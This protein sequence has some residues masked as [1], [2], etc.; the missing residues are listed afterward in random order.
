MNRL[1]AYL[2]WFADNPIKF[3]VIAILFC[4]VFIRA[5][6]MAWNHG[7]VD[8]GTYKTAFYAI[9][10]NGHV[11]YTKYMDG[12]QDI[13][14]YPGLGFNFFDSELYQDL[15]GDGRIDRIRQNAAEWKMNTLN[16]ILIRKQDYERHKKRFD[17]ADVLL[18]KIIK[19]Y[20]AD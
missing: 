9:G 18:R 19:R 4:L 14:L 6:D 5:C 17:E 10:L 11:E 7:T 8:K 2:H 15:D 13:L 16:E 12:S 1:G 3:N 20:F